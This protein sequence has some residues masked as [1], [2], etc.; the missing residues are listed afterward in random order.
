MSSEVIAGRHILVVE[1]D[2]LIAI[3]LVGVLER[4]GAEVIGPASN[5]REALDALDMPIEAATLDV[6]LGEEASFPI[7]DELA[8]RG[9]PFVFTTGSPGPIPAAHKG[10]AICRKPFSDQAL[11]KALS[12][13]LAG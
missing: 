4:A 10:R 13:A 3:D 6:M 7:A 2:Y 1:D 5:V 12:D 8:R 11:L 9:I